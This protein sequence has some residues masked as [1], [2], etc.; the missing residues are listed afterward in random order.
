ME[1]LIELKRKETLNVLS[2]NGVV[3]LDFHALW[4]EPCRNLLPT[5]DE[6]A[7]DN[8]DKLKII[9]INVDNNS[10]LAHEYSVRSIPL[11]MIFKDGVE[12]EKFVGLKTKAEI[13]KMINILLN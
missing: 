4:C 6:L 8:G 13:Q 11:V 9:K 12:V 3:L 7:N 10:E 2:E 5:L 1:N